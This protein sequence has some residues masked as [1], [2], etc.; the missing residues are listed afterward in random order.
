MR[1]VIRRRPSVFTLRA[2]DGKPVVRLFQRKMSD[3]ICNFL[4]REAFG[5]NLEITDALADVCPHLVGVDHTRKGDRFTLP[6][7]RFG[8][9]V[10]IPGKHAAFKR[11]RPI[12]QFRIRHSCGTVFLSGDDIHAGCNQ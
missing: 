5:K 3:G 1:E 6:A 10:V 12:K 9:Q 8:D 2:M 4:W 7:N 11:T